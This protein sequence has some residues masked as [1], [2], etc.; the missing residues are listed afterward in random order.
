[1]TDNEKQIILDGKLIP[2][3]IDKDGKVRN[4]RT[5]KFLSGYTIRR[6]GKCYNGLSYRYLEKQ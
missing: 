2:Y 6:N 3:S 4:L 5:G 1:L